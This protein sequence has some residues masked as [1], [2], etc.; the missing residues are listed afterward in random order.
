[1]LVA[2]AQVENISI[3]SIDA[4]LDLYGIKRLW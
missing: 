3:V 2:Q 4:I 1:M